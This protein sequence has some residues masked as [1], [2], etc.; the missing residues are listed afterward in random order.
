MLEIKEDCPDLYSSILVA[1]SNKAVEFSQDR[2]QANISI[3]GDIAT[4][5]V[6]IHFESGIYWL[7]WNG[8]IS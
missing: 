2:R 7:Q 3:N 6:K 4:F 1:A 8:M 5:W